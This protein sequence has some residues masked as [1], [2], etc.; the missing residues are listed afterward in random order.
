ML[1]LVNLPDVIIKHLQSFLSNDDIHYFL[2]CNKLHFSSLKEE[3]I[4]FSLNKEKSREYVEDERFRE[5]IL[6][7]VKDGSKQIGLIFDHKYKVPDI[8]DIVAQ[9]IDFGGIEFGESYPHLLKNV[10]S[11]SYYLP[12]EVN[13][14]P[15]LPI[16]QDLQLYKCSNIRDFSSLSHLR[17]LQLEEASQLT[18][19]TSLLNIPDLTFIDCPNI[20]NFSILSS[21][22]Q[23]FLS[24]Y[25]STLTDVSFLRNML[26]VDLCFLDLLVDV[27]PLHGVKD[28]SLFSCFNIRDISSLGNHYRL[29]IR[30]CQSIQRGYECFRTVRHAEILQSE[31][32]DLIF[33][34]ELKRLEINFLNSMESQLYLLKDIPELIFLTDS[35]DRKEVYDISS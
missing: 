2:N 13:E 8:F 27:S 29:K 33:F 19:L 16:L 24:I 7:K 5:M 1:L 11:Q 21:K 25:E 26:K 4:Y 28:L 20:Q 18:D 12:T 9:K 32:P 15:F 35:M 17:K 30:C 14:I 6:S 34:Q 22:R 23:Q 31:V 3:T 10:A